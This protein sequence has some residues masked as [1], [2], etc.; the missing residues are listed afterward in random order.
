MKNVIYFLF[1][2]LIIMLLSASSSTFAGKIYKWTDANGKIHYGERP[3]GG[4]AEQIKL[5]RSSP[6]K[7]APA[8]ASSNKGDA[9]SKFLESV[10]TERKEKKEATDKLAKE[11]EINDK[12][13]SLARRQVAGLKQGGRKYE[14]NEQGERAYLDDTAIQDRLNEAKNNVEKWCK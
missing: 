13:C 3:P 2:A 11:K 4:K 12:N 10:A 8:K 1:V 6:Y 5:K 14:V 7:S 9:S